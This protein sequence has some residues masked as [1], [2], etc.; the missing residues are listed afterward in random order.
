MQHFEWNQYQLCADVRTILHNWRTNSES[1]L[2]LYYILL[3]LFNLHVVFVFFFHLNVCFDNAGSG[4]LTTFR[5]F[6]ILF[7]Q[8]QFTILWIIF[9]R[10]PFL[11][12]PYTINA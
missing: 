4:T 7:C 9:F 2:K 1:T 11:E 12:F 10:L 8:I 6:E 3:H 5:N